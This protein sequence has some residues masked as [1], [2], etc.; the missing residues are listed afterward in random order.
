[1]NGVGAIPLEQKN[2]ALLTDLYEL[3]MAAAYF[4]RG[5]TQRA[6]FEMF[7]RELPP[8]R[9]YLVCAGLEQALSYLE[10]LK[11]SPDQI[12]Y[13]RAQPVF[14]DI[15]G[16]FWDYLSGLR[17]TG[18]VRAVPEGTVVFAQEPLLSVEGPM[19]EAQ[20]VETF[21]LTM[22]NYQTLVASKA[23]RL[24]QAA[25]ADGKSRAV[26]D[27]GSRRAHGPDAGV[28]AARASYI[29]GCVATSNVEAGFRMSIPITGTQAHSF[30]M[31]F[32]QEEEAFRAFYEAFPDACTLLIDTYDVLAGAEK[33]IQSVPKMRGVRID[34]GD[35]VGLSK[36]VRKALDD[37]A[38]RDVTI[39]ASGD[40]NEYKIEKMISEGAR[41]DAFGVGTELVTSKDAPALGGVYKL[42]AV[43]QDGQ[44]VP[45]LK[46]SEEKASYPGFKQVYRIR[47]ADTAKFA[48]DILATADEEPP[49]GAEPLLVPVMKDGKC[50][51]EPPALVDVR[52][53][54]AEQVQS[55]PDE[56]R[57]LR[58]AA[59]YPVAISDEL[60]RRYRSLASRMQP[61]SDAD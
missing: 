2:R 30:V 31:A 44:W 19:V 32:E 61:D 15:S 28:L 39:V 9:S 48:R 7:I 25:S 53:R 21:L 47:D 1:L 49:A 20:I 14:K 13:L 26:V 37:A 52:R 24:V 41:V 42:V 4:E 45:R 6:G 16:G 54:A 46:L 56:L 11:F 29:G 43:E 58:G 34:S 8:E 23:A 35:L 27:F 59:E 33:A 38:H 40:L 17:F 60:R 12:A 55:L 10:N 57:R 36:Q 18:S 3:T 50:V 51:A 22:V 5:I